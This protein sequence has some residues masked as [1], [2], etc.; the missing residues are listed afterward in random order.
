MIANFTTGYSLTWFIHY[1]SLI[2]FNQLELIVDNIK[3]LKHEIDI[4]EYIEFVNLDKRL[5]S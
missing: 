2:Y 4:I 1:Y 3:G 5:P